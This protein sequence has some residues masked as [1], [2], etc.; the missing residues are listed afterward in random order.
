LPGWVIG[1]A[2]QHVGEV[3]LRV[4]VVELGRLN[5]RVD[6]R[7]AATAGVGTGEQVV[8]AA[9]RDAAQGPLVG[10]AQQRLPA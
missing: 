8:L 9:N 5:Q 6:R 2:G 3:M 1:D 4:D 7:D 10:A